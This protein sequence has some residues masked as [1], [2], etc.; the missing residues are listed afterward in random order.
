MRYR[1]LALSLVLLA[2]CLGGC[3][4]KQA[5]PNPAQ[6]LAPPPAPA[7]PSGRVVLYSPHGKEHVGPCL[8]RFHAA[9]PE[10]TVDYLD[11]PSGKILE[12]L[13]AESAKPQADLWWG[14]PQTMFMEGAKRDLL[15]P[16][17][18]TWAAAIAPENHDTADLWYG[19]YLTPEVIMYNDRQL[20]AEDAPQDWDDLLDPKW[21]G[22]IVLRD[23]LPSGTMRAIFG[24]LVWRDFVRD[25]KPDAGY[26]WLRRL[27]SQK[28]VYAATPALMFQHLTNGETPVTVWNMPDVFIQRATNGYPFAMVMPKS[29]TP[30]LVE[31]LALVKGGPNAEAAKVFYEWITSAD[32][33]IFQATE[34][35]RLPARLDLPA[36]RLPEWMTTTKITPMKLD[37]D[38][39]GPLCDEWLEHWRNNIRQPQ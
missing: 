5:A 38:R 33:L 12:R 10:I 29:G 3:G 19:T 34:L 2:A 37:W 30:V 31:G 27:E 13:R 26:D 21:Q 14:A 25:G 32:E 9:H 7:G 17:K 4:D 11:L 18:P 8:E 36:E 39:F 35:H 24:A 28:P 6:S 16:Y 20:K 22:K 23:P 1:L 15:A